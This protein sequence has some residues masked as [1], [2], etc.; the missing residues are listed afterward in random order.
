VKIKQ[1]LIVPKITDSELKSFERITLVQ[2]FF[3]S[4]V[5]LHF[6]LTIVISL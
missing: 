6:Q 2:F 4:T 5:Q 1:H 3:R